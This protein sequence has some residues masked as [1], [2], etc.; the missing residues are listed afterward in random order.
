MQGLAPP[1]SSILCWVMHR[2]L[3]ARTAECPVLINCIRL[4]IRLRGFLWLLFPNQSKSYGKKK[5]GLNKDSLPDMLNNQIPS[6]RFP[7]QQPNLSFPLLENTTASAH[8]VC[9]THRNHFKK[10]SWQTASPGA[11]EGVYTG[12]QDLGTHSNYQLP[13][14]ETKATQS[15]GALH[16]SLSAPTDK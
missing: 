8:R 12:M 2:G 3:C 13:L 4:R 6:H 5:K 9:L 11:L 16:K 7:N 14:F 1:V 15:K 10:C